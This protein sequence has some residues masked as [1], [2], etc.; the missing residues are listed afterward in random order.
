MSSVTSTRSLGLLILAYSFMAYVS[1]SRVHDT[2][3]ALA[4]GKRAIYLDCNG[5]LDPAHLPPGTTP[6]T[7][8][9]S[10]N[11]FCT[12][13]FPHCFCDDE[14]EV[15]CDGEPEFDDDHLA[16]LGMFDCFLNCDCSTD[17]PDTPEQDVEPPPSTYDP[18]P[19]STC[20]A[21]SC[22]NFSGC[23]S[24]C[25][26]GVEAYDHADWFYKGVC[27]HVT[28]K[29]KRDEADFM[30]CPCNGTYVSE[31]CCEAPDGMVFEGPEK[32]LG[33]LLPEE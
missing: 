33:E 9:N 14:N 5:Q 19:V 4:L 21:V 13:P 28:K 8:G 25:R 11:V 27:S 7:F 23:D 20:A 15:M 3:H 6:A 29:G 1:A 16:S 26:C 2:K 24:G 17:M 30:A 31:A 22:T 10:M 18:L 32:K 12:K